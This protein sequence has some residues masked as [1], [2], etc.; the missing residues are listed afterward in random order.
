MPLSIATDGFVPFLFSMETIIAPACRVFTEAFMGTLALSD[1]IVF[2]EI[3]LMLASLPPDP[4]IREQFFMTMFQGAL[5]EFFTFRSIVTSKF[6]S[7]P[8]KALGA[9]SS[10]AAC[11]FLRSCAGR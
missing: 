3:G 4:F 2:P 6:R 8:S 10:R 9:T 11:A 5:P 1:E 7:I